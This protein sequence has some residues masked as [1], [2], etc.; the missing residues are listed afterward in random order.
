MPFR[1]AGTENVVRIQMSPDFHSVPTFVFGVNPVP[2]PAGPD[3]QP[4]SEK[5]GFSQPLAGSS[6]T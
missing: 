3:F 4:A 2:N 6:V 1:L 5:P